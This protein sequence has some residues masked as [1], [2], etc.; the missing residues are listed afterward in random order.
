MFTGLIETVGEVAEAQRTASGVRLRLRTDLASSLTAGD[1]VAVNGVC[2]TV[3]MS[4]NG[5][6]FADV[7]PETARI[8]TLGGLTR[9]RL[10]N[11]ERAMRADARVGGHFVQGHVDG[12]GTVEEVRREADAHWLTISFPVGLAPYFI[13]KGSIAVDGVSLTVAGLGETHFDVMIIPFTWEHTAVKA[14]KTGER[15]NLECDMIGKYV[16]RSMELAGIDPRR[17]GVKAH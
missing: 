17:P 1:S 13:R 9:G 12:T 16:A 8:T 11:L 2:L 4:E 5:A 7:G 15:V 6:L 14:L 10:V 3:T